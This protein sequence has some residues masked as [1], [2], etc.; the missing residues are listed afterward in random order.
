MLRGFNDFKFHFFMLFLPNGRLPKYCLLSYRFITFVKWY[1][2]AHFEAYFAN[3]K[4]SNPIV[5]SCQVCPGVA[6]S[7]S[8]YEYQNPFSSRDTTIFVMFQ[9]LQKT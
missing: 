3:F 5:G 2:E 7:T 8:K 1:A 4:N 9:K 6:N